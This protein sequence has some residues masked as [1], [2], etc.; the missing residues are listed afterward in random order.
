MCGAPAAATTAGAA[1]RGRGAVMPR[2]PLDDVALEALAQRFPTPFYLYDAAGMVR[3]ARRLID[4]FAWAPGFREYFAV[5]ATPTP[6]IL[7]LLAAAGCGMDCSSAAELELVRRLAITGESVMFSSN[8][9]PVAEFQAAAALGAIINL[10]H[11]DLLAGL[12]AACGVPTTLCLRYNPGAER[13][14]NRIIG[15]PAESKFGATRDQLLQGY[16]HAAALGVRRFGLH[17]MLASNERDPA[18]FVATARMLFALAHEIRRACGVT[19]SFIN[20]GG[21]IGIPYRPDEAP[22]DLAALGAA[23][24]AAWEQ[25]IAGTDLAGLTLALECGRLITG[26]H[27]WLVTR[28][29]HVKHTYRH[30]AGVDAT[31]ADLMRP[32]MY[33]AYHHI[34]L[35]NPGERGA[36]RPVDVV[37]SLCEN[38]DKFAI[39]RPLPPLQPG[40]L[41][42]IHDAGAHGRAM[43]FNYNG[44]LR[45]AEYLLAADGAVHCIRRAETLDDLF[46]TVCWPAAAPG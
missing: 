39:Q 36:P 3:A 14:G 17:A 37:G 7:A 27:G 18:Y 45:A 2:P 15:D 34:T 44:K 42:L 26:P 31:M 8:M 40:D 5:K 4:A 21:G 24:R 13:Q 33:A 19:L 30:Y 11:P 28:V 20:L 46:A 12:V 29:R 32:G 25:Q 35:V 38:N 23:I 41:L 22:V 16:R 6:A 43:G 10:D 9:T 1:Q